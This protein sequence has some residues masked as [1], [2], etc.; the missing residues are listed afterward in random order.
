MKKHRHVY[1]QPVAMSENGRDYAI[2]VISFATHETNSGLGT[3]LRHI[4]NPVPGNNVKTQCEAA[5]RSFA[6]TLADELARH[7]DDA[8]GGDDDEATE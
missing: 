6:T 1:C 3:I 4:R 2:A 7:R 8:I 5:V